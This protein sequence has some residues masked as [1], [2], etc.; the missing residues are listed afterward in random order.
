MHTLSPPWLSS[1]TRSRPA[2]PISL[3][4][5]KRALKYARGCGTHVF[6]GSSEW[7]HGPGNS[8]DHFGGG[9]RLT[10]FNT[11]AELHER[12]EVNS[13]AEPHVAPIASVR[14]KTTLSPEPQ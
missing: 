7:D 11:K 4:L 12:M 14:R 6:V 5:W 8:Y 9:S 13:G 1:V 3:S 10:P 2:S